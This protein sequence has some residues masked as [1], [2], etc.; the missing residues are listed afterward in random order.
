MQ[1][2]RFRKP[3]QKQ[4]KMPVTAESLFRKGY[5]HLVSV[6]PPGAI[7]TPASQVG[8][9]HIGKAPGIRKPSGLWSGYNWRKHTPTLADAI[10]WDAV[11][12]NIGLKADFFPGVDIDTMDLPMAKIIRN[13]ALNTL[14]LAPIRIGNSPKHTLVYRTEEPFSRMRLWIDDRKHLVEVLGQGQQYLVAGT[15]PATMQPYRW[16]TDIPKASALTLIDRDKAMKFL[17]ALEKV[18]SDRGGSAVL[19]GNGR[20][21]EHVGVVQGELIAPSIQMLTD[22]VGRIPN[23]NDTFPERRDYLRMGYAIKAS[24]GAHVAK[25]E[26]IFQGWAARWEGNSTFAGNDPLVVH[27]DYVRMRGPFVVGWP[28]IK[29]KAGIGG[30]EEFNV[31]A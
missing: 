26:A 27:D 9:A 19:E 1:S 15:H 21:V 13:V 14:G 2:D 24:A 16:V 30:G 7:L 22:A 17:L 12:A 6:I 29:D 25:G 28:W 10:R 11:G 4:S 5:K 18:I 8:V 31:V 23:D 20:V 3:K